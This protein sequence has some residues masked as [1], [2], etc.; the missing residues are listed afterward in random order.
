MAMIPAVG[1]LRSVRRRRKVIDGC[2]AVD[3]MR[4]G[5]RV[6]A[7]PQLSEIKRFGYL[8]PDA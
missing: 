1:A 2:F 7:A 6:E 3:I 5:L 4:D 8:G